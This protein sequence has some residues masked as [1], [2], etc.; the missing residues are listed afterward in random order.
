MNGR[1]R[2]LS[3]AENQ[4]EVLSAACLER[5]DADRVPC[6]GRRAVSTLPDP[7]WDLGVE[8]YF[9]PQRYSKSVMSFVKQKK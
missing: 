3:R 2:A 6:R 8:I 9:R 7:D 1:T 4:I 5:R